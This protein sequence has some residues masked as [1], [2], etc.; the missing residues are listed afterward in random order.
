MA[1]DDDV[2]AGRK[3]LQSS[4]LGLANL[5]PACWLNKHLCWHQNTIGCPWSCLAVRWCK[6]L[7]RQSSFSCYLISPLLSVLT[8]PFS[9][10]TEGQGEIILPSTGK[11]HVFGEMLFL[12]EDRFPIITLRAPQWLWDRSY[13]LGD[14]VRAAQMHT[15]TLALVNRTLILTHIQP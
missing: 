1:P 3:T 15:E 6:D 8:T 12:L 14:Q 5:L 13:L 11:L 4:D 9:K 7:F 2:T 10:L